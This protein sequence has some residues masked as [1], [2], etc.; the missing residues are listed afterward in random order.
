MAKACKTQTEQENKFQVKW[1]IWG[2][3]GSRTWISCLPPLC[4]NYEHIP[5]PTGMSKRRSGAALNCSHWYTR[6]L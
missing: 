6:K 5:P 3:T 1:E 2:R 4:C